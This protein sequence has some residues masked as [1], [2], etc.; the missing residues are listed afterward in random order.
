MSGSTSTD[1]RLFR[2]EAACR[3][4]G[5]GTRAVLWVQGC[6]LG[7]PGCLVPDSWPAEGESLPVDE[8][9]AWILRCAG[10]EG[11]TLS[12]GEPMQQAG[13]LASLIDR[14]RGRRDLGVMCY[15]GYRLEQ[16]RGASQRALL[17]RIDL[18]VDGPYE[19][20][21]HADLRWRASSN[22][23]L[24]ALTDRYRAALDEADRSAGLEFSFNARGQFTFAGVPPWPGYVEALP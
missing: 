21:R 8:V 24:I 18:L 9:A 4:L 2:R 19:A 12:G 14:V 7:C 15:T 3:V 1:L 11:I 23:R 10:I 16:L 22:Q 13:A 5:P 17:E 6:S 20:A